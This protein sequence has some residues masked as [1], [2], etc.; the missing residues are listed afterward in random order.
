ML[1]PPEVQGPPDAGVR[2]HP[3]E[4]RSRGQLLLRGRGQG[5]AVPVLRDPDR[6]GPEGRQ[7]PPDDLGAL[8][9]RQGREGRPHLQGRPPR[10]DQAQDRPRS[11]SRSDPGTGRSSS[12]F[13]VVILFVRW[14]RVAFPKNGWR[15]PVPIRRRRKGP[16]PLN[17]IH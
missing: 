8:Q 4:G 3:D 10:A 12:E 5:A 16:R 9:G 7:R 2:Q 15:G 14:D 6:G 13:R 1:P 11:P 17:G